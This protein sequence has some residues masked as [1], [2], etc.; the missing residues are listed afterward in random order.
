[1]VRFN[2]FLIILIIGLFGCS[3]SN[4]D[5]TVDDI[6][7]R[8]EKGL[9]YFEKKKFFRA[10][11]EFEYV[12]LRGRHT[13][14]ADDAQ[15]YLAES[16]FFNKEYLTA[17]VE[18][19]RLIRMMG[20]QTNYLELSRYRICQCY[21]EESPKYYHDQSHTDKAIEKF[22]EF[23]ED[24]P[25]S[26][27]VED[28]EEM[29]QVLRAKLAKKVY[30][31]AYLYVKLQEYESAIIYLNSLLDTYY[32]TS[33]ADEGRLLYVQL[34]LKLG[35]IDE[36]REYLNEIGLKS[37]NDSIYQKAKSLIAETQEKNSSKKK[38]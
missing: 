16:Y 25:E 8:Y 33:W 19:D 24:F 10:Q 1:M 36:A 23:I 6:L 3:G 38:L 37:K 7:E 29:I 12:L 2:I 21:A 11:E 34:Y 5:L 4:V 30:E 17:I 35:K 14:K 32:D 15:Y 22:Q 26:E 9:K 13:D 20:T 18:Y 27:Y 28:A 31:S